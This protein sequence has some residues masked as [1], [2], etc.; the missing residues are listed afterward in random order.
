MVEGG[1]CK[2]CVARESNTK[3]KGTNST[4]VT[5]FSNTNSTIDENNTITLNSCWECAIC[6]QWFRC[7]RFI[8]E[9]NN[10]EYEFLGT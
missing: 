8:P 9:D 6:W 2:K 5:T 4:L 7:V 3:C 10:G 1:R